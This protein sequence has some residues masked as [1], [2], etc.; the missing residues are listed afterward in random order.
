MKS[1]HLILIIA[2]IAGILLL[3]I[4]QM[5]PVLIQTLEGHKE[6][7]YASTAIGS[8]MY[9]TI[10]NGDILVILEKNS[11]D[12]NMNIGDIIVFSGEGKNIAH[13]LVDIHADSSCECKNIYYVKGDNSDEIQAIT[14]D[15]ILGKVIKIVDKENIIGQYVVNSIL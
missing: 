1:H 13:R 3:I 14:M 4:P 2:F 15:N 8:S 12:F 9:P 6:D 11:S 5:D 7:F 10:K